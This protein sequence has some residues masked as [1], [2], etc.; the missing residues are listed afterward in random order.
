MYKIKPNDLTPLKVNNHIQINA[1]KDQAITVGGIAEF[2]DID[3]LLT[4]I[5]SGHAA[6]LVENQTKAISVDI[7]GHD[8]RNVEEPQSA[9][10]IKGPRDG[11]TETIGTNTSLIRRRIRSPKLWFESKEIGTV[12]KTKVVVA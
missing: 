12:T 1:L 3:T 4:N 2:E 6:L 9:T 11:F 8:K 7:P 5:L 10:L